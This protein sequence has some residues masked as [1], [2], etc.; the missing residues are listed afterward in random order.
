[1]RNMEQARRAAAEA[2]ARFPGDSDE[3]KMQRALKAAL[4]VRS[5]IPAY[6]HITAARFALAPLFRVSERQVRR[7]EK[8]VAYR[9]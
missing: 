5:V 3:D 4:H 7:S 6:S 9:T 2:L 8:L 1:M